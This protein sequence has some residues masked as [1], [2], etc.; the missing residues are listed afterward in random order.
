MKGVFN[1]SAFLVSNDHLNYIIN[2]ITKHG[3]DQVDFYFN[4]KRRIFTHTEL[5]NFL[6][7]A[8]LISVNTRYREQITCE[9]YAFKKDFQCND[10]LQAIKFLHCL[11]YQSCEVDFWEHT[12]AH[13]LINCL[14]NG[15]VR[16]LVGYSEKEWAK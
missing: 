3:K 1:M 11:A 7:A 9:S 15:L 2:V 4:G 6:L 16:R 8:N 5:G 14:I 13:Y 12:S 10:V